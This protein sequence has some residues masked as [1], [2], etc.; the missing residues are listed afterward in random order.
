MMSR[1]FSS[2]VFVC[3]LALGALVSAREAHALVQID[4]TQGT[5]QPMPIAV[6]DFTGT[7]A[8]AEMARNI[9][10]VVEADLKRS[11]LFAPLDHKAFIEN[12]T[13]IDQP[14][15]FGDWRIINV[16]AL[17][18]G[19]VARQPDG[20]LRTEF[21]LWDVFGGQQMLGQQYFT[22]SDNWRRVAQR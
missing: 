10:S 20:R 11:G 9:S 15:R 5:V 21:R 2:L 17:V 6:T 12:I 7:G 19:R 8:E 14:P 1:R 18:T 16:Q 13:N 3:A 4:I 22:Q